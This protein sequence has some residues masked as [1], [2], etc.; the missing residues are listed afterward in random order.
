MTTYGRDALIEQIWRIVLD[1]IVYVPLYHVK[2]AWAMRGE[3]DLPIDPDLAP[4][5]RYAHMRSMAK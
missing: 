2:W 5:F 1:D 4:A 3:L